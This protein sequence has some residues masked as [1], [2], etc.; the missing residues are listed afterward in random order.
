MEIKIKEIPSD[1][2]TITEAEYNAYFIN[3]I[4]VTNPKE[5]QLSK[6]P[7]FALT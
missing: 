5:R 7:T 1:I 6:A 2:C 4:A 3:N